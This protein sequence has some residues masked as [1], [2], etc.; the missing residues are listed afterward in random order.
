ML[1]TDASVAGLGAVLMQKSDG[2]LQPVAYASK[3]TS[4]AEAKYSIT[5]LECYAVVWAVK[6]LRTYLYG[7]RFTVVT[8]HSALKWLMTAKQLAGRLHRWA[9]TLQDY[10]FEIVHTPGKLNSVPD[11]LSRATVARVNEQRDVM[12]VRA[13]TGETNDAAGLMATDSVAVMQLI[14]VLQVTEEEL[15]EER[16]KSSMVQKL[17]R[18]YR[19]EGHEVVV[20]DGTA[21]VKSPD[22]WKAVVPPV[23]WGKVLEVAHSSIWSGH[24]KE[25]QTTE[26]ILRAYWWPS[27]KRV[28]QEWVTTCRDCGSRKVPPP[29]IVPPLRP[30]RA[31]IL[32]DRWAIDIAGPL[33]SLGLCRCPITAMNM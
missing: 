31:G 24:L 20:R 5:E 26:K 10:N 23:L 28:V 17:L 32:R 19:Y 25:M 21:M 6:L 13:A 11:A 33:I 9:I 22:G 2:A 4:E 30:I 1:A 18:N 7:R 12:G 3:T 14:E 15:K 16:A 29:R 27:M 8:D